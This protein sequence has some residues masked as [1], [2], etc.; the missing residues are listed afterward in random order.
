MNDTIYRYKRLPTYPF[1]KDPRFIPDESGQ[2]GEGSYKRG[3]MN[4]QHGISS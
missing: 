1:P 2:A 3:A 4:K